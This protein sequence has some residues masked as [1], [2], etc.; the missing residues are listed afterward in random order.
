MKSNY[1]MKCIAVL[2]WLAL[3]L[4]SAASMAAAT[5]TVDAGAK[6]EVAETTTLS[7]LTI[8]EGATVTAPEGRSLSMT[9]DGVETPV[10][11]GTYKG[12]IVLTPARDLV[13]HFSEQGMTTDFK[14]RQGIYVNN[15]AYLPDQSVAAAVVG[16]SVTSAA[17]KDVKITSAGERFNGIVVAGNSTYEI[18][19]PTISLNGN[20]KNDFAGVGAAIRAGGTSKVTINHATI[21]NT[22]AVR[23]AI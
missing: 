4:F 12:K 16:G 20:G 1:G 3:L 6:W 2:A 19:H 10:K 8:A 7:E 17:A 11:P 15:G 21:N 18:N 23:T 22:G 5:R 13:I 9:V 14:F